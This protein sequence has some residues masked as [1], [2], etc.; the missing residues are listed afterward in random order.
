MKNTI[1]L[2]VTFISLIFSESKAQD[3]QS[4]FEDANI[5]FESY[6]FDGKVDYK[7]LVKSPEALNILVEKAKNIKV[8]VTDVHTYQAFWINVYN[9]S[10]IKGVV[11]NYPMKSPL[12]KKGF[13]DAVLYDVGGTKITLNDIENKKLRGEFKNEAR[14][15]FVL[16]CAGL[17]CPPIISQAYKPETLE[18]QLQKQTEI[19]LNN[20]NFIKVNGKKVQLSQIFEWYKEDFVRAG[21]E[22]EFINKFR[23]EAID[24]KAK[25][26]YYNYD[27]RLNEK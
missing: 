2:T 12:D 6:V 22:I 9:L 16:V 8:A 24:E 1:I 27:W 17:G 7:A 4:F 10:V 21:T 11:D 5:F 15:H 25:V 20:P 3:T 23:K 19:A 13:F 26:S 18:D 14:F